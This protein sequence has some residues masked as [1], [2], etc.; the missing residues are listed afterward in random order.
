[1]GAPKGHPRYGGRK[2]TPNKVT[3]D[4][5]ALLEKKGHN[6]IEA[7]INIAQDI[8]HSPEIRL[9]ANMFLADKYVPS[10]KA[11]EMSGPNGGALQVNVNEVPASELVQRGIDRV[12]AR[13]TEDG[14]SRPA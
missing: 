9:K 12:L 2:G 1:M 4:V 10:L 5:L 14:D 7:L 13:R 11:I 8:L 6:P 3:R